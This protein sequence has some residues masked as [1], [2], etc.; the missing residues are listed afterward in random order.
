MDPSRFLPPTDPQW[1]GHWQTPPT[2]WPAM[3]DGRPATTGVG[4]ALRAALDA[5]PP[6]QRAVV[7]L[8][9]VAGC[10]NVDITEIVRQPPEQVRRLLHHGRAE[11]R[12]SLE[13]H[14]DAAKPA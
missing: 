6:A 9:D 1:P 4:A 13:D 7:G 12:R 10:D 11:L 14:F 5:L 2:V 3:E 8:R